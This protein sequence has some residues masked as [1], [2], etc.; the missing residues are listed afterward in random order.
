M[1]LRLSSN[2]WTFEHLRSV[3]SM[4]TYHVDTT[5]LSFGVGYAV[6]RDVYLQPN[7]QFIPND[8]RADR[9][10]VALSANINVF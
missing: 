4:N 3:P 10:N 6:I 2:I 9:T 7:V 1:N 5:F 8:I